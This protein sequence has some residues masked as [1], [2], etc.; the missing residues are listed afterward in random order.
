MFPLQRIITSLDA[1]RPF[2][3][4]V[5]DAQDGAFAD[6]LPTTWREIA[7]RAYVT[8]LPYRGFR[9]TGNGWIAGLKATGIFEQSA[10]REQAG[11]LARTLKASVKGRHDD[12]L[13]DRETLACAAGLSEAWVYNA[14]ESRLL[15]HLF[16]R[17]D[18]SWAPDDGMKY[19]IVVPLDFGLTDVTDTSE[20]DRA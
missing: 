13:V 14:I 19:Y 12:A 8:E 2:E 20:S 15:S 6:V 9:L 16:D 17:L 18:A 4:Q 3:W 11:V 1:D 5:L 7:R 10:F